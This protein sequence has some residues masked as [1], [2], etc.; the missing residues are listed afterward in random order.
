MTGRDLAGLKLGAQRAL[1]GA[2]GSGLLGVCLE[3]EAGTVRVTWYIALD[4]PEDEREDMSGA[5]AEIIADLPDE[6]RFEERTVAI[7]DRSR[8]LPTVGAWVFLQRGLTAG[9]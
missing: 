2:V 5:G 8:P 9:P 6:I 3:L 1:L 7:S 4:M